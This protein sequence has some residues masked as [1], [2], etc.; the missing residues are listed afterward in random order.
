M[1]GFEVSTEVG[2]LFL[3]H[4]RAFTQGAKILLE[5]V[6][7][8]LLANSCGLFRVEAFGFDVTP[9]VRLHLN[10]WS[11]RT[12]TVSIMHL[13]HMLKTHIDMIGRRGPEL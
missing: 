3:S 5:E 12:H 1:A 9:L 6:P 10:P 13:D 11:F 4:P 8:R 2:D 7:E